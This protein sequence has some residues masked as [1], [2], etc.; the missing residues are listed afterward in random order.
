MLY[1]RLKIKGLGTKFLPGYHVKGSINN[2]DNK[3]DD[4]NAIIG[5][6]P[7]CCLEGKHDEKS[8]TVLFDILIFKYQVPAN[9]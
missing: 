2:N 6:L 5:V 4:N 7:S 9:L 8:V 3:N 1:H